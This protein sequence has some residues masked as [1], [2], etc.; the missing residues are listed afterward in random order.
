MIVEERRYGNIL[1]TRAST[2]HAQYET[3]LEELVSTRNFSACCPAVVIS[4]KRGIE[5]EKM[6]RIWRSR[7]VVAVLG[8]WLL[9]K[10]L[11]QN[12]EL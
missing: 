5:G 11:R 4:R 9:A 8:L 7:N 12:P 3:S 6:T 1:L 2:Q 10:P